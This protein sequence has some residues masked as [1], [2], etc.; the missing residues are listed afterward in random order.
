MLA[1]QRHRLILEQLD[2]DTT[3]SIRALT[4]RFGVSRE[5]IRKDIEHLARTAKLEQV[6][7]GATRI[8]TQEVPMADRSQI[9]AEGKARIA[10]TLAAR[11][12]Q[13]ASI[14]L[15]NGSSTQVLAR[16]LT[17][18][19]G[20]SVYTNDLEV[21]RIL[22]PVCANLVLIGG[23]INTEEMATFGSE[24]L[25]QASRYHVDISVISA[26][27]LS[28]RALLTDF[29]EEGVNLR[30]QIS[31]CGQTCYV[32]ADQEKFGV[33]G[34]YALAIPLE[35]TCLILDEEPREDLRAALQSQKLA[36]LVAG[37]Q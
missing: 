8:R 15:D 37:P 2:K 14:F 6:R 29:S 26:G 16:A 36:F 4:Q 35:S 18:H 19:S 24:A 12:P 23:R 10:R 1:P 20:L 5:T 17:E 9:N 3:V 28:A 11:I 25:E 31:R 22:A 27:G 13:G 7:G 21:A 32:I 33:V 34:Q 30:E